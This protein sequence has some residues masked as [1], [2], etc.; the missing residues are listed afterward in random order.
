MFGKGFIESEWLRLL[1]TVASCSSIVVIGP[2]GSCWESCSKGVGLR[3]FGILTLGP[4]DAK[5]DSLQV[6]PSAHAWEM[7]VRE[8]IPLSDNGATEA[9]GADGAVGA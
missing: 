6:L 8:G 4:S 5:S 1:P 2:A 7:D 9:K 3:S